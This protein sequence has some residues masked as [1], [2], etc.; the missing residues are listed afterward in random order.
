MNSQRVSGG[1]MSDEVV[2]INSEYLSAVRQNETVKEDKAG[3]EKRVQDLGAACWWIPRDCVPFAMSDATIGFKPSNHPQMVQVRGLS[4]SGSDDKDK[5]ILDLL[6]SVLP[7]YN[8]ALN[9]LIIEYI[10]W[11]LGREAWTLLSMQRN[12]ATYQLR[13]LDFKGIFVDQQRAEEAQT[14]E[15]ESANRDYR[16]GFD[17]IG[18]IKIFIRVRVFIPDIP[19]L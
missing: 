17:V 9:A 1:K 8:P 4:Q 5:E 3:L 12:M 7:W 11:I 15:A 13:R 19:L 10:P 16:F 2:E 6:N 18:C 14:L